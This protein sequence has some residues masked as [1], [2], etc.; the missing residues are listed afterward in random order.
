MGLFHGGSCCLTRNGLE[1]FPAFQPPLDFPTIA[2]HKEEGNCGK[3][4]YGNDR[5][6]GSEVEKEYSEQD[7]YKEYIKKK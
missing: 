2:F 7:T 6:Y 4:K 3:A 5:T 1:L